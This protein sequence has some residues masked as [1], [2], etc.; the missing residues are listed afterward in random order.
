MSATRYRAA[1]AS[2][3]SSIPSITGV[4]SAA[5]WYERE[6]WD[7]FGIF[8]LTTIRMSGFVDLSPRYFNFGGGIGV[9]H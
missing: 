5:G 1:S 2:N 9:W 3:P 4:Y 8:P 7:L 6:A